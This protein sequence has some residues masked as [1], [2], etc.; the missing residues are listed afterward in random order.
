MSGRAGGSS[1]RALGI[2]A[3]AALF[4]LALGL[5]AFAA[6]PLGVSQR[7]HGWQLAR[8][9]VSRQFF[10]GKDGTELRVLQLGKLSAPVPVVLLH[11][12]GATSD[13]WTATALRLLAEGRTVLIPDAPG[14]G[15]S[16]R[17]PTPEGYGLAA[18]V[19]AVESLVSALALDKV[20]LVGHSLGGWTAGVYAL[21]SP[22]HVRRLVLVDAAG[23]TRPAP[24]TEE[25]LRRGLMPQTPAEAKRF[26]SYLFV[27]TPFPRVGCIVAGLARTYRHENVLETVDRL[28]EEDGLLGRE[29]RLPRGTALIWGEG[30][31]LFPLGDARSAA[32]RIP[33]SRLFVI[34][35][36]GHDGPLEAPSVFDEALRRALAP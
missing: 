28:R 22:Y 30:D 10:R 4:V 16:E 17:P 27:R 1:R 7:V 36:V 20:D 8:A 35:G 2:L 33:A 31:E 14:S 6:D 24:G 29:E 15:G 9:G 26:L 32:A 11:G 23:L 25:E 19:A 3:G 12:L 21:Q 34:T 18:R 13:Y 5:G